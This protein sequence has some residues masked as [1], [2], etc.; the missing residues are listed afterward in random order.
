MSD[1]FTNEGAY[2]WRR[3][4]PEQ[5]I[6]VLAA[7]K[8]EGRP[9]HSPPHFA[10]GQAMD[11]HIT[12]AC[13]EHRPMIGHSPERMEEFANDLL[14]VLEASTSQMYAWCLL[15]NH[16]HL[17]VRVAV[18]NHLTQS[19]GRLHGRCSHR[20]NGDDGLRGRK[21]FYRASDRSIRTERHFWVTVNYI[22]HNPVHHGYV[23]QWTEWPWSS[24]TEFL[25]RTGREETVRIWR[26]YP[27]RNF[28]RGWDD[29]DM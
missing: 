13:Y 11:Y 24:A 16:Y 7:R 29:K 28:G 4:S 26:E 17:L 2:R 27:V 14:A 20:W 22:H 5:R 8:Q 25:K 12:A 18:L 9:W 23:D 10:V 3:L 6:Q 15:P 21:I 19:L 1:V